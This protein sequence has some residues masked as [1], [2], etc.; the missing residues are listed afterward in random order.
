MSGCGFHAKASKNRANARFSA[1]SRNPAAA[2]MAA[3]VAAA[4]PATPDTPPPV[5]CCPSFPSAPA[6]A[7]KWQFRRILGAVASDRIA[8][9]ASQVTPHLRD[10]AP[11]VATAWQP[12]D[13]AR[14]RAAPRPR[15]ALC[16]RPR[17]PLPDGP[18]TL[19]AQGVNYGRLGAAAEAMHQ[20]LT[21]AFA[22]GQRRA[23]VIVRR[24]LR[25]PAATGSPALSARAID[26]AVIPPLAVTVAVSLL[27]GNI[28]R[29]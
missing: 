29:L 2:T 23:T 24:A 11:S 6:V 19:S 12:A 5:R 26:S 7:S 25:H 22:D 17:L 9:P 20:W 13:N 3:S 14:S 18:Q 10:T 1:V 15:T 28:Q 4:T 21:A 8:R 27:S 16:C